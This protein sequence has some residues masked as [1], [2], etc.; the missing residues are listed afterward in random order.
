[1][2][3]RFLS[4]NKA[5]QLTHMSVITKRARKLQVKLLDWVY[6]PNCLAC[7]GPVEMADGLCGSCW[8]NLRFISKPYC[9]I[10]GIPFAADMGAEIVSAQAIASPPPFHRAR[11]AVLYDDLARSL[12][13]QF[14]YGDRLEV[15]K[16]LARLMAQAGSDY[17]GES[18]VLVPVPLHWRR[19]LFR[20]YNQSQLLADHLA[21]VTGAEV[22]SDWIRRVKSTRQQVGLTSKERESNVRGAF[23]LTDKFLERYQGE[24]IVIIDDVVTT[25]A[26]IE[27]IARCFPAKYRDKVNVLSF[28]RVVSDPIGAI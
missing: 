24:H 1:M 26:T 27:A 13:S 11:A 4:R 3:R 8:Q 20:K 19:R 6:P 21:K 17:W 9:P 28:A 7:D 14:K 15:A 2:V 18:C 22:V 12:V 5:T 10:L 16:L 23:K 25:G